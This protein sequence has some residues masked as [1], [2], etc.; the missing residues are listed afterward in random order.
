MA[1]FEGDW[2]TSKIAAGYAGHLRSNARRNKEL[3]PDPHYTY[4]KANSAK[5]RPDAP[6]GTRPGVVQDRSRANSNN[7]EGW[8]HGPSGAGPSSLPNINTADDEETM[9]TTT[10]LFG[11]R[12]PS[13]NE[14]ESDL[15]EDPD[16]EGRR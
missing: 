16:F 8:N 10:G 3:A 11:S 12:N 15:E 2:A 9:N 7:S 13:D 4:L 1:R 5:R 6:R 14:N